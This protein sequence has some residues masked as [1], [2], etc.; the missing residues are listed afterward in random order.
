MMSSGETLPVDSIRLRSETGGEA[1]RNAAFKLRGYGWLF[2]SAEG[3]YLYKDRYPADGGLGL[4]YHDVVGL[5]QAVFNGG[6]DFFRLARWEL[7]QMA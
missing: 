5:G 7:W 4:Y 3:P 2:G 6:Q 1:N